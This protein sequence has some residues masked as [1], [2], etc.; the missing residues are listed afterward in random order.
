MND[1]NVLVWK[2]I[3]KQSKKE[4]TLM[5]STSIVSQLM[6]INL[7]ITRKLERG[8]WNAKEKKTRMEIGQRM[9]KEEE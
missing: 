8:K 5:E 7:N 9:Q 1:M 4:K 2:V 3:T 6:I